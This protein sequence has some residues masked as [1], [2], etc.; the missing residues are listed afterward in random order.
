[1]QNDPDS[2]MTRDGARL[3]GE[4]LEAGGAF[5][6]ALALGM[7]TIVE[8]R[9]VRAVTMAP[10]DDEHNDYKIRTEARRLEDMKTAV[11]EQATVLASL[12]EAH[13][14]KLKEQADV[15]AM[16]HQT[17]EATTTATAIANPMH[18][19]LDEADQGRIQI[20]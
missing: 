8:V 3:F 5:V 17:K 6:L 19:D 18:S 13:K 4:V 14:L 20:E 16:H 2:G 1:M 15:W 7:A 10:G 11:E 9:I 12:T